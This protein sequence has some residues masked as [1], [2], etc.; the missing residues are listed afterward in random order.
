MIFFPVGPP[1]S[2]PANPNGPT[3][4]GIPE[5]LQGLNEDQLMIGKVAPF[6]IPD[7]EAANCM[8]CDAKFTM[9]RRRHHCRGCGHVLCSICC[10]DKF[11]LNYMDGKE[12]RVCKPCKNILERLAKAEG[13]NTDSQRTSRPNPANPMEYCSTIP[14]H[15]Q[16]SAEGAT[17]TPPSVMVPVGVL[18]RP[19]ASGSS[20]ARP[21]SDPKS[22]SDFCSSWFFGFFSPLLSVIK[23]IVFFLKL[24]AP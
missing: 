20:E 24:A 15:Q 7:S 3:E 2:T 23:F 14:P 8:I 21:N 10:S 13:S 11:Q 17:A 6:W 18:K 1:G 4:A 16:V 22:V 12:G 5:S 9:V 19:D